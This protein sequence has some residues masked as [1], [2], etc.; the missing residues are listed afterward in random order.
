[1]YVHL[2]TKRSVQ[3]AQ[4]MR[5]ALLII[6]GHATTSKSLRSCLFL[7]HFYSR[8]PHLGIGTS[9]SEDFFWAVPFGDMNLNLYRHLCCFFPHPAFHSEGVLTWSG[10]TPGCHVQSVGTLCNNKWFN[11]CIQM[12]FINFL[13]TA[14]H[15]IN[16]N[17][18]MLSLK[19][20]IN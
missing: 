13:L 20:I 1:M 19:W 5:T 8:Y 7:E 3:L 4:L 17:I 16:K 2:S 10:F 11:S 18:S 9:R 15:M 14:K 6:C 12:M